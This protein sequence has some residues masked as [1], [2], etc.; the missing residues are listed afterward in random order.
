MK[1]NK[2]LVILSILAL[3]FNSLF[4]QDSLYKTKWSI[5]LS[6][7]PDYTYRFL[8]NSNTNMRIYTSKYYYEDQ[9]PKAGFH[10]FLSVG[11]SICRNFEIETGLNFYNTGYNT[12]MTYDTLFNKLFQPVHIDSTRIYCS[13]YYLG[14]PVWIGWRIFCC[15]TFFFEFGLGITINYFTKSRFAPFV[16]TP[17]TEIE[18]FN[19]ILMAKAGIGVTLNKFISLNITPNFNYFATP[20]HDPNT[21]DGIDKKFNLYS[22]GVEF[23]INVYIGK[24]KTSQQKT[25]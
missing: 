19:S 6:I 1:K 2:L 17:N 15:K 4:A 20:L 22:A 24:T 10:L 11:Y 12:K 18:G 9:I 21:I 3:N 13:F 8:K 25:F 16:F 5:G 23:G 14:I 7:S